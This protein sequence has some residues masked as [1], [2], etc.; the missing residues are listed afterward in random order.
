MAAAVDIGNLALAHLGD[1]ASV[2][3][4]D[5][6]EG[7]PQAEHLARFY[8]I[9]RDSLLEQ[10]AWSFATRTDELVATTYAVDGWDY[11]FA[12][13]TGVLRPLHLYTTGGR[14]SP[15]LEFD[16]EIGPSEQQVILASVDVA[17]LRSIVRVTDTTKFSPLFVETLSWLLASMVAGPLIK[18][19]SGRTAA[20]L[21]W[22]TYLARFAEART[23][24][25]NKSVVRPTLAPDWI[26]ARA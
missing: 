15:S 8:P 12:L 21:C 23:S 6:P 25:A 20:K 19:N 16:L 14:A 1:D 26:T 24:D 18:G 13:P 9:A 10:H 7:S 3:S 5:P 11:A 2:T 17:S 4:F 22:D